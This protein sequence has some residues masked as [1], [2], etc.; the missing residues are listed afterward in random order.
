MA[1]E[2]TGEL[3]VLGEETLYEGFVRLSRYTFEMDWQGRTLRLDREVHSHGDV[4]AVLPV[5]VERG[6]GVLIRQF[7]FIPTLDG[8]D[9]WLWEIPAGL[10][11]GDHPADCAVK[12]ARE[13]A[14]I[15]VGA[16]ESLGICLSSP[17]IVRETVSLFWGTYSGPPQATIG[18]LDH[19]AEM[20]EIHELPLAEI[21]RMTDDG[22]ILD[23]KSAVAVCR[24]RARRPGLFEH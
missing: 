12:E 5:D 20:I 4:A 11:E 8:I 2:T 15:E 17:G 3:R 1:D 22:L 18:G 19:E 9:G 13:E 24:L 7:R 10:L 23:A 14:R 16:L 6:T 21:A